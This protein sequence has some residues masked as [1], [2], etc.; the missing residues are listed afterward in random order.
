[1]GGDPQVRRERRGTYA[2]SG[3]RSSIRGAKPRLAGLGD[4]AD[5]QLRLGHQADNAQEQ[6]ITLW[7]IDTGDKLD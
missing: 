6:I 3:A 2:A 7:I 4:S 1:M 5:I